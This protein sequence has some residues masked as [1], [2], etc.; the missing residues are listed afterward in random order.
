[1]QRATNGKHQD[2]ARSNIARKADKEGGET[3]H[4]HPFARKAVYHIS[5]KGAHQQRRHSISAQHNAYRIFCSAKLLAKI[6]RQQWREQI[7]GKVK[8]KVGGHHLYIFG[9]PQPFRHTIVSLF[10]LV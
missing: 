8:Q 9:V 4:Q 10:H 2:G 7:K 1:M 6:Q 5:A 3:T